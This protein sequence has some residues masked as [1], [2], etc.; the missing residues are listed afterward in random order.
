MRLVVLLCLVAG[1]YAVPAHLIID[2][3]FLTMPP[4]RKWVGTN[5]S[6]VQN[7]IRDLLPDP[8]PLI[9]VDA[10]DANMRYISLKGEYTA[11]IPLNLPSLVHFKLDGS[12]YGVPSGQVHH[13]ASL[14]VTHGR[15]V[16]ITGG[17]YSCPRQF[18]ATEKTGIGIT[19]EHCNDTLIQNLTVSGCYD[20]GIRL[21][22][23]AAVEV[24]HVNSHSH[25]R[26]LWSSSPGSKV[27]VIDS[28]FH[29]NSA[30]G[31]DLDVRSTNYMVKANIM[32]RNGRAGVFIEE[33]AS[34]NMILDNTIVN[35][36][37]GI[38]FCTNQGDKYP[39]KFPNKDNWVVGNFL[40]ANGKGGAVSFGPSEQAG[41]RV[42]TCY[43]G[44]ADN[45]FFE[46]RISGNDFAWRIN[47][48]VIGNSVL[49]SDTEDP[50]SR[51]SEQY[52][53]GNITFFAEPH[54]M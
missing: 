19:C 28:H 8:G 10:N 9:G 14:V 25:N 41:V 44:A 33:G 52:G 48:S 30:D 3:G 32:E 54:F 24:R 20:A 4:P 18:N 35:N 5:W 29:D 34:N 36:T 17:N 49:T 37:H 53:E 27:L 40:S 21:D 13:E 38:A 39:G 16:S 12:V 46:N 11:D 7:A 42:R 2:H 45:V 26:G 22:W 15:F 31:V 1:S 50:R 47:G 43:T 6:S 23:P 51:S